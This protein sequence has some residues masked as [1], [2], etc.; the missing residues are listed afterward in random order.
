MEIKVLNS[1]PEPI[2]GEAPDISTLS[3]SRQK[4]QSSCRENKNQDQCRTGTI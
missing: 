1:Y 3:I 2:N 4:D